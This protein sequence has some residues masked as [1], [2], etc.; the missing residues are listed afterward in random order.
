MTLEHEKGTVERVKSFKIVMK[1]SV[2]DENHDMVLGEVLLDFE[3][4][5]YIFRMR[6]FMMSP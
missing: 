1:S 5:I 4:L 2:F 6:T 3:S